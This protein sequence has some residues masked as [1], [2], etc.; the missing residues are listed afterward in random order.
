MHCAYGA[1]QHELCV[2]EAAA[3]SGRG[4]AHDLYGGDRGGSGTGA[5]SIWGQMGCQPS[6]HQPG[7]A[8]ELGTDHTV[9]RLPGRD[10]E[11]DLYNKR[12][13]VDEH[14]PA[15]DHQDTGIVPE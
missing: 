14:E 6:Q 8:A 15:Q 13:G 7:V 4:P 5:E 11:G 10:T 12:S 2:M 9:L 3:G 1:T